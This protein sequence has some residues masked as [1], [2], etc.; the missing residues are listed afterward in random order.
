MLKLS[1]MNHKEILLWYIYFAL[2]VELG[3][4]RMSWKGI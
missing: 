4:V 3:Y 1:F 2:Y